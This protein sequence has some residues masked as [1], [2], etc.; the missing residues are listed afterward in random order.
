MDRI[1]PFIAE[2]VGTAL[3]LFLGS[4]GASQGE[5]ILAIS[6]SF[7]IGLAIAIY[8]AAPISGGHLNPAVT[9]SMMASKNLPVVDGFGYIVS[10]VVGAI[11]GSAIGYGVLGEE[12][13]GSL[14]M[15]GNFG[16]GQGLVA[17]IVGT[18][19]LVTIV[20]KY[21][22]IHIPILHKTHS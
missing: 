9:I 3:F 7:G 21:V 17:E 5:G 2:F 13:G 20:F 8:V 22:S 11:A 14:A 18:F 16:A 19:I 15:Q 6:T 4:T 10:Q 12:F 1:R